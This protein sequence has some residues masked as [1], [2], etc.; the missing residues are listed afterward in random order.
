MS[1]YATITRDGGRYRVATSDGGVSIDIVGYYE[2]R[3]RARQ[4]ITDHGWV[5]VRS[6]NEAFQLSRQGK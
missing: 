6:W 3:P 4:E 2:T 5:L 1:T